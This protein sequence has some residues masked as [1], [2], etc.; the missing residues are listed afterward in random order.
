MNFC[1]GSIES[2]EEINRLHY[3]RICHLLLTID[4]CY[5]EKDFT[6]FLEL[7]TKYSKLPEQVSRTFFG[8][9][10][11][12]MYAK[13]T[14][15]Q[16]PMTNNAGT[17]NDRNHFYWRALSAILE[18]HLQFEMMPYCN[19]SYNDQ[20]K[21]CGS[22]V[23]TICA[24]LRLLVNMNCHNSQKQKEW[25][26]QALQVAQIVKCSNDGSRYPE[27]EANFIVAK[28][29]NAGVTEAVKHIRFPNI[30]NVTEI[31]STLVND[32]TWYFKTAIEFAE[33]CNVP[34]TNLVDMY[35]KFR[36]SRSTTASTVIQDE[37][38]RILNP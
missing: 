4:D 28:C 32:G 34:N 19:A 29:W 10:Y 11:D 23:E 5:V 35:E 12:E 18:R 24:I 1:E 14:T 30:N 7:L 2:I 33:L 25:I 26:Q 17:I 6:S 37:V 21:H 16:I 15:S 20:N 31:S 36:S 13:Y 3:S 22:G 27:D 8:I 9:L 38:R